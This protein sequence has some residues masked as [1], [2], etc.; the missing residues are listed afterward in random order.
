MYIS[1]PACSVSLLKF[2]IS[3]NTSV[4]LAQKIHISRSTFLAFKVQLLYLQ[5]EPR[6]PVES[7]LTARFTGGH[8]PTFVFPTLYFIPT[9]NSYEKYTFLR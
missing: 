4:R 9:G 2:R 8:F 5:V 1:L 6:L 3:P 7:P